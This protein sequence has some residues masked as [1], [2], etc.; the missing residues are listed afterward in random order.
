MVSINVPNV[1]L[2]VVTLRRNFVLPVRIVLLMRLHKAGLRPLG[3]YYHFLASGSRLREAA[4][5]NSHARAM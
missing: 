2:Q 3:P 5:N 4:D 1:D